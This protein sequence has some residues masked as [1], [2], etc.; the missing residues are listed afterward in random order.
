[1]RLQELRLLLEA[2][3]QRE[4]EPSS[5]RGWGGA[6]TADGTGTGSHRLISPARS[7]RY[8]GRMMRTLPVLTVTPRCSSIPPVRGF[9]FSSIGSD[10]QG[11]PGLVIGLHPCRGLR[12]RGILFRGLRRRRLS[13]SLTSSLEDTQ[14]LAMKRERGKQQATVYEEPERA[15]YFAYLSRRVDG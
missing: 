11:L 6:F 10:E 3:L 4:L 2:F 9:R 7:P 15:Q 8:P 14:G 1:M 5:A 13:R 12:G